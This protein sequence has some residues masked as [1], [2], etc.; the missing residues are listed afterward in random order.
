MDGLMRN[1]TGY[2]IGFACACSTR[3]RQKTTN[4][5]SE[6][7]QQQVPSHGHPGALNKAPVRLNKVV[8][9]I[10][11]PFNNKYHIV[12]DWACSVRRQREQRERGPAQQGPINNNNYVLFAQATQQGANKIKKGECSTRCLPRRAQHG[13][14]ESKA[15]KRP[16]QCKG[17]NQGKTTHR[18]AAR[19]RELNREAKDD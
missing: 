11:R 12:L 17:A 10:R 13:A 8:C 16:G 18:Q 2:Q 15:L 14:D 6:L 9:S 4:G 19:C 5:R 1:V 3:R 7:I